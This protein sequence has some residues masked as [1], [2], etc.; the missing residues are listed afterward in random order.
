MKKWLIIFVLS[1]FISVPIIGCAIS[2]N[3]GWQN[4]VAQLKIDIN[5]FSKI[6]TRIAL[7]ESEIT[8]DD[9]EL[10]KKYLIALRDLLAVPGNPNFAGARKLVYEMLPHECQIY[11]LTII[12]VIERYLRSANIDVT[13]N[14]ELVI[15][16]IY[17]AIDGALTAVDEFSE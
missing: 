1:I 17:S 13:E 14:Q 2:N 10:I 6:A 9:I 15:S 16:L 5:M 4:N 8:P 12:D 7:T 11:G 3:N